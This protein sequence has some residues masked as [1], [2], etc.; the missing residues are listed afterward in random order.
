M[1]NIPCEQ[2][3][4]ESVE[5]FITHRYK[6]KAAQTEVNP[7]FTLVWTALLLYLADV[8]SHGMSCTFSSTG[9][10]LLF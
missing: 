5:K 8:Y 10:Y 6:R 9:R 7:S 2:T 3:P 4:D 1:Q